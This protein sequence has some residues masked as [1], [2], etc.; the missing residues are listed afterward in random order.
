MTEF[1]TIPVNMQCPPW[2]YFPKGGI[3][4]SGP[5]RSLARQAAGDL[6]KKM[7][8]EG[9]QFIGLVPGDYRGPA[10][11]HTPDTYHFKRETP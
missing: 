4:E 7:S 8:S 3:L 11:C 5:S 10:E 1:K 2:E 9:W 6:L